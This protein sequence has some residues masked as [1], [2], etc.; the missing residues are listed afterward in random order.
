MKKVFLIHGF[1]GTPNGGW[2][3]YIMRELEKKDIYSFSLSMPKPSE[4][5]MLEWLKEIERY[6]NRDINDDIYLVGH[7]LGG[8]AIL[9]YLEKFNSP[10]IKGVIIVSA[11][12]HKNN[13]SKIIDFFLNDFDWKS[14]K[15][16]I[17][18]VVVIH[19]DND[20]NVPLSDAKETATELNGKL[21]IIPNGKHL[22]GS[23]GFNE[24]PE[25][26]SSIIEMVNL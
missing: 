4:P 23:A 21:I 18:N 24:L 13:N 6:I 22:N 2:R 8:T 20:P 14:I 1:N 9:R 17:S 26:L 7:S 10:N 15:N 3:P 19:G 11:P 25:A 16:K 12:C 5:I